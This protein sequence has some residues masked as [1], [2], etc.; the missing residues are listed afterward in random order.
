MLI[1]IIII[2]I[3]PYSSYHH[4]L[5]IKAMNIIC[6]TKPN[7][8]FLVYLYYNLENRFFLYKV[9]WRISDFLEK[10]YLIYLRV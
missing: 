9:I 2:L 10:L 5:D 6:I 4:T 7:A 3:L 1:L 8:P